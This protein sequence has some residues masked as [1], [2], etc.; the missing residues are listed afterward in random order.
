MPAS[1]ALLILALALVLPGAEGAR[2]DRSP[3][4]GTAWGLA[5]VGVAALLILL[6]TFGLPSVEAG[7]SM[8]SPRFFWKG[9]IP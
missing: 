6:V 5:G 9:M 7:P 8:W 3:R 2:P 1:Q 4:G